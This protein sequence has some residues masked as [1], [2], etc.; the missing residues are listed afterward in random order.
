LLRSKGNGNKYSHL[1]HNLS[2]PGHEVKEKL[3]D[4]RTIVLYMEIMHDKR[5]VPSVQGIIFFIIKYKGGWNMRNE[6][7]KN[8]NLKLLRMPCFC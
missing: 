8:E 4:N 2:C 6:K 5:T 3:L 7:W 1:S